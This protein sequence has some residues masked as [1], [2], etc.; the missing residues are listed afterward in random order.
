MAGRIWLTSLRASKMRKMS[1][2]LSQQHLDVD[3]RQRLPKRAEA[4]PRVFAEEAEGDVVGRSA[5]GLDGEQ[6]GGEPGHVWCDGHEVLGAHPGRQERLVG[7]TE[8]G[9]GHGQGGL[10]AQGAGETDRAEQLQLL[11]GALGGRHGQVELGQLFRRVEQS[12]RHAVGLV[13]GDVGQPVE[14]LGAAVLRRPA[15]QQLRAFVDE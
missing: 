6:F 14:H 8:G 5:P 15:A 4:F 2:P 3:V 12:Q 7:I 13:D 10:C 9:V 1:T 11:P